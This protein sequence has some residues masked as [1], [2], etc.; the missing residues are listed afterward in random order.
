MIVVPYIGRYLIAATIFSYFV[1]LHM[2]SIYR[3]AVPLEMITPLVIVA[4]VASLS[5][6]VPARATLA[7]FMLLV[8]AVSIQPGNWHRRDAWLD[9]FIEADVPPLPMIPIS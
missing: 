8:I 4:A 3:Y 7:A 1:W 2:F 6:N 5:F 9:R